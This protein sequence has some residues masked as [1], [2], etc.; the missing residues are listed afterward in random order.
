MLHSSTF[1]AAIDLLLLIVF[2]LPR[3]LTLCGCIAPLSALLA[4]S[5]IEEAFSKVKS[6]C[7]RHRTLY[8]VSPEACIHSAFAQV[9]AKDMHGY[10]RHSG[11]S[12]PDLEADQKRQRDEQEVVAAVV[13]AAVVKRRKR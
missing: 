9:T 4:P 3:K 7:R 10:M 8:L 13:I 5:A 11:Y 6:Y 12:L 1:S 2:P